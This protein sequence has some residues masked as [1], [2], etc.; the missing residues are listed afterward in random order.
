[1][2]QLKTIIIVTLLVLNSCIGTAAA[3]TGADQP[4]AG[5]NLTLEP[6]TTYTISTAEELY[7]FASVVNRG[8]GAVG[9]GSTVIL[10]DDIVLNTGKFTTDGKTG[11]Y[12]ENNPLYNGKPVTPEINRWTPIGS[13][14][15][16]WFAGTFD[17]QNHSI[18]GLFID[19]SGGL[20][21]GLF[22]YIEKANIKNVNIV[23]SYIRSRYCGSIV[24]QMMG[25]TIYNCSSDAIVVGYNAGGIA[26]HIQNLTD[27]AGQT[28]KAVI[29]ACANYGQ[30][31]G[32]CQSGYTGIV[33]FNDVG[34]IVGSAADGLVENCANWGSVKADIHVGAI[35]GSVSG[36]GDGLVGC[37]N[38]GTSSDKYG[39]EMLLGYDYSKSKKVTFTKEPTKLFSSGTADSSKCVAYFDYYA[40]K[41]IGTNYSY[42][43]S[44][45]ETILVEKGGRLIYRIVPGVDWKVSAVEGVNCTVTNTGFEE[46]TLTDFEDG[47]YLK[48]SYKYEGR[49]SGSEVKP[50]EETK[51]PKPISPAK[52]KSGVKNTTIKAE[53][54]KVVGGLIRVVWK[55]SPGY[56]VDYYQ[57]FRS[58]KKSI[59][60]GTKPI[61]TTKSGKATYYTNTKS[62]KKGV[63]YYYKLRGVRVIEGKKYYTQWSNKV[64]GIGGW[65]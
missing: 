37:E 34:G 62:V 63:K 57:I 55:K 49:G 11:A 46:Y 39:N 21:Q 19:N 3:S 1:M 64:Y 30:V 25:G 18:S 31:L 60:Y 6:G 58:T 8:N 56:K 23:N 2:R 27:R 53:S 9:E 42:T 54:V 16:G 47:A 29:L 40:T 7:N 14:G 61:Y 41:K 10:K 28:Q 43:D 35:A 5:N 50:P 13:F 59:G 32:G 65:R 26:G 38:H 12:A 36:N 17:G 48:V 52:L 51:P 44:T 24:G 20:F 15:G 45:Q 4:L 22:G 33:E